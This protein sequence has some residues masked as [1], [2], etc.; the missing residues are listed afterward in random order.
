MT[1]FPY[2][3][4]T[5]KLQDF[6]AK[7]QGMGVPPTITTKWL[8]SIGFGSKNDRSIIKVVKFIGFIDNLGKPTDKWRE[9]RNSS[10]SR[11]IMAEGI[12]NGYSELYTFYPDAHIRTD[13]ELKNFFRSKST[14]ADDTITRIVQTYKALCSLADFNNLD[15][16]N[17][18][19]VSPII[20]SQKSNIANS[21]Q[22]IQGS[23]AL[24]TPSLHIDIQIHIASDASA[25]QIDQIFASM[26]KHLYK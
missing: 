11:G 22:S 18:Q 19:F 2:T 26:S 15:A 6:F 20:D 24:T 17:S 3:N 7:I 10:K 13:E 9:Y 25:D 14:T 23:S 16:E 5:G 8:P 12:L 4:V 21:T 1:D